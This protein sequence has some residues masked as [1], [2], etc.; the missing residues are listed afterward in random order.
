[1]G[2]KG[3]TLIEIIVAL[4]VSSVILLGAV[5][6]L[7]QILVSTGRTAPRVVALDEMHRAALKIKKDIQSHTSANTTD[8]QT[9][10]TTFEWTDHSGYSS[11]DNS[12]RSTVYSLSGKELRRTADNVTIIL[13]RHIESVIFSDNE[14]H[15]SVVIT[16]D[17]ST[18]LIDSE[19]IS[20]SVGLRTD[21]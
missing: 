15:V 14:T 9:A 20:F 7:Q 8:L 13:G 3:F 16:G 19:T 2:E 5:L 10:P 1:M 12:E 17:N 18:S 6:S 4:A 11:I 21:S